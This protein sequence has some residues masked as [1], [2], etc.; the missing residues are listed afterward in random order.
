MSDLMSFQMSDKQ[1]AKARL[2]GF[3]AYDSK[4][5]HVLTSRYG[6][7]NHCELL[8]MARVISEVL[9]IPIDRDANRRKEVL[10]KW[11]SEHWDRIEPILEYVRWGPPPTT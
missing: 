10:I 9:R 11:F 2:S 4:Q 5:W 3:D 8:S 7:M 1:R 6:E